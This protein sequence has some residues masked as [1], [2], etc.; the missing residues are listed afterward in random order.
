MKRRQLL[1]FGL[2]GIGIGLAGSAATALTCGITPKQTAGPFYPVQDQNDK[3]T[4]LTK[5]KGHAQ[6]AKGTTVRIRGVV[7]DENCLPVKNA[8][9][10]IWQACHSGRYNHPLD[11][12]NENELDPHF[13]YWGIAVTDSQGEYS[14]KTI[15]P[16]SYLAAPGWTRPPHVHFKVHA[17]GYHELITQMYFSGNSLNDVDNILQALTPEEQQRVVIDFKFDAMELMTVGQFD[18]ILKK[19]L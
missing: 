2:G 15:V 1:Q 6:N 14:F 17:M 7:M 3:D 16:G 10:E 9:V 19:V 5:V 13:Q 8:V 4:D 18:I 11:E 12:E